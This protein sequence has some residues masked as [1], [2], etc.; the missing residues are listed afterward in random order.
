MH[1]RRKNRYM[2]KIGDVEEDW[3]KSSVETRFC[4][5]HFVGEKSEA[6]ESVCATSA[7]AKASPTLGTFLTGNCSQ[8]VKTTA[9]MVAGGTLPANIGEIDTAHVPRAS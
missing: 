4:R 8:S 2:N 5:K 7:N 9:M 6:V 1:H 3:A